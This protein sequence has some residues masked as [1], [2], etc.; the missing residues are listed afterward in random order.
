[1]F[2]KHST[3]QTHPLT[4]PHMQGGCSKAGNGIERMTIILQSHFAWFA[5]ACLCQEGKQG[6]LALK[7]EL[8]YGVAVVRTCVGACIHGFRV[9]RLL[10]CF[11]CSLCVASLTLLG[12]SVCMTCEGVCLSHLSMS[13]PRMVFWLCLSGDQRS[14]RRFTNM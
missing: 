13:Y 6:K 4:P 7:Q 3:D 14:R 10:P 2:P 8:L 1:M 11:R 5:H 9:N 12:H